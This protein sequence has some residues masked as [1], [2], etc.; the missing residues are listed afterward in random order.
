MTLAGYVLGIATMSIILSSLVAGAVSARSRWLPGWTGAPARLAEAVVSLGL[1]AVLSEILGSFAEFRRLPLVISAVATGA[2]LVAITRFGRRGDLFAT[3]EG[4]RPHATHPA[5]AAP[6]VSLVATLVA[7][8]WAGYVRDS[9]RAGITSV[10]SIHYHLSFAARF[11]QMGEVSNLNFLWFDPIWTFYA[12]TSE[13]F[14]AVGMVAFG[15]DIAS[16]LLNVMWLALALLAAWVLGRPFGMGHVAVAMTALVFASPFTALTQSGSALNDTPALACL[17]AS[18][19]LLAQGD[20]RPCV[21]AVAG[22]AAGL[23]AGTKVTT[24]APV[25]AIT[26]VVLAMAYRNRRWS[27]AAAWTGATAV[28]GGFWYL[29]NLVRAGSPMPGV[30]IPGFPSIRLPSV[31]AYGR[32]VA[33]YLGNSHFWRAVVP[34]GFRQVFGPSSPAVLLLAGTGLVVGVAALRLGSRVADHVDASAG[35]DSP[36]SRSPPPRCVCLVSSSGPALRRRGARC[37]RG[38]CGSR[39]EWRYG[40]AFGRSEVVSRPPGSPRT[41]PSQWLRA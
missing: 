25:V 15:R 40:V 31:D 35:L 11:A 9:Y 13:L 34:D 18:L 17:L 32:T 4:P 29:R 39:S 27:T 12:Q 24:L 2:V 23:A 10:D 5:W 37:R 19:A 8:Q 6:V 1:L 20:R 3:V 28:I 30:S 21:F 41:P 33:D 14:H 22:I 26:V 36:L 16:P 38:R 7:V